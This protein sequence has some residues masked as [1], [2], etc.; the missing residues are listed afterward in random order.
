MIF[1]KRKKDL[2]SITLTCYSTNGSNSCDK[3]EPVGAELLKQDLPQPSKIL[4][5]LAEA[6][7]VFYRNKS[8]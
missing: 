4:F 2:L 3:S 1:L 6:H 5:C 7:T 8:Y